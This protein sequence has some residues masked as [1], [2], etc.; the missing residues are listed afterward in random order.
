M[1][2]RRLLTTQQILAESDVD[3]HPLMSDSLLHAGDRLFLAGDSFLGKSH[4]TMQWAI[5]LANGTRFLDRYDVVRPLSVAYL[6]AEMPHGEFRSRI[7]QKE[8]LLQSDKGLW[9]TTDRS[10]R[11]DDGSDASSELLDELTALDINC[12][13]IDSFYHIRDGGEIAH[14]DMKATLNALDRFSRVGIALIIIHHFTKPSYN[15]RG[16]R[17][18]IGVYSMSG[19]ANIVRWAD[20]IIMCQASGPQIKWQVVSRYTGPQQALFLN[21]RPDGLIS[22]L[23]EGAAPTSEIIPLF[24][25]EGVLSFSAICTEMQNHSQSSIRRQLDRLVT[26]GILLTRKDGRERVYSLSTE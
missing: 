2:K 22:A 12:L 14:Q 7:R 19:H 11:V 20:A 15:Y 9:W 10:F 21:W 26:A 16:E 13:F 24:H 8:T 4:I 1:A 17:N 23:T 25:K 3:E 6:N 5:N 18:P